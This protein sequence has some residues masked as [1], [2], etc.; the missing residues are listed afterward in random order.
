MSEIAQ[1]ATN[2]A[3]P[4]HSLVFVNARFQL[5]RLQIALILNITGTNSGQMIGL[6]IHLWN[7]TIVAKTL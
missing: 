7:P 2:P 3:M 6:Q 5:L 1:T 4:V